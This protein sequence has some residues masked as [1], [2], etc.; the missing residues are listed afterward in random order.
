MAGCVPGVGGAGLGAR[1]PVASPAAPQTA[2]STGVVVSGHPPGTTPLPLP[3]ASI[4]PTGT[5]ILSNNAG[6]L[7]GRVLVP[8]GIVANNGGSVVSNNSGNLVGNNGGAIIA[9]N[10]GNLKTGAGVGSSLV[11]SAGLQAVGGRYS[12]QAAPSQVP[13]AGATVQ[14]LD[15]G[16]RPVSGPDGK[17]LTATTDANGNYAFNAALPAHNLIVA[18][19]LASGKGTVRAVVPRDV[20]GRKRVDVDLVSTLTTTYILN[21]YV[22]SQKDPVAT[23]EKLPADVEKQ[24]RDQA[25]RAVAAA[26]FTATSLADVDV[27]KDVDT[28][29]KQDSAFDQQMETVKKLLIVAGASDLGTGQQATDVTLMNVDDLAFAPDGT[30]YV[31]TGQDNR[32]W[33]VRT[34]G[35]IETAVGDRRP[36]SGQDL[37]GLVAVNA[38]LDHPRRLALDAAGHL[39][40]TDAHGIYRLEADG[41]LTRLSDQPAAALAGGT[42]G[43]VVYATEVI[44]KPVAATPDP[45]TGELPPTAIAQDEYSVYRVQAG[46]APQHLFDQPRD[47]GDDGEN[48]VMLQGMAWDGG[49]ACYVEFSST[50]GQYSLT[51]YDFTSSQTSTLT[52]SASTLFLDAQGHEITVDAGGK[53]HAKSV[54]GDNPAV[55][56][57]AP[58]QWASA[59][60]LAPDGKPYAAKFSA[61]YRLDLAGPVRVAGTDD[62]QATGTA[63][64]FTFEVLEGC[65]VAPS[66]DVYAI[67]TGKTSIYHVDGQGQITRVADTGAGNVQMLRCDPNGTL[68]MSDGNGANVG[69]FDAS[70]V[71]SAVQAFDPLLSDFQVAK[72][73]TLYATSWSTTD[74]QYRIYKAQNGQVATIDTGAAGCALALDASGKLYAA[75]GGALRRFDG[76]SWTTLKSDDHFTLAGMLMTG[77]GM[78][79]DAKGRFYI[80]QPSPAT[81]F[82]YDASSDTFA[83]IA[84][85]G[86]NHFA[87]T[88]VDDGIKGPRTP[89]F[90]AAGNLYFADTGNRQVKR[91][92]AGDL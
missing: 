56:V 17:P 51:K 2:A 8:A 50:A 30:L 62:Q 49:N 20:S 69:R 14:L 83:A 40:F 38:S 82:R 59:V 34:D 85:P 43:D 15:A 48:T 32:I 65:A 86:S 54:F 37:T 9:N 52:P 73:G 91:I 66:G 80:A 5:G 53:W 42:K 13:L 72:D 31:L 92:A 26:D 19:P 88:G 39:L 64:T 60:A 46:G 45:D 3:G 67:D 77:A 10:G 22:D 61:V 28:L 36:P 71:W 24:T 79:I 27:V 6:S 47:P 16:G 89:A 57:P 41:K 81:V 29:R 35:V 87:G 23:L 90:D 84:G 78:A 76:T 63:T 74:R 68:Y 12:L 11:A 44:T 58:P 4:S 18:A 75:G 1:K 33:R 7:V 21:Q 70:H 55:D 25:A